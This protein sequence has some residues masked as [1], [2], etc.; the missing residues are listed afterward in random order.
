MG[1]YFQNVQE[2][3]P[4]T[5]YV[6]GWEQ[7]TTSVQ[8]MVGHVESMANPA[9][10]NYF[11]WFD[12]DQSPDLIVED[13]ELTANIELENIYSSNNRQEVRLVGYKLHEDYRII[14]SIEIYLDSSSGPVMEI[15]NKHSDSS[16][17][18]AEGGI[19]RFI[20]DSNRKEAYVAE[21]NERYILNYPDTLPVIKDAIDQVVENINNVQFK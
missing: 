9:G 7:Q 19:V 13:V 17:P 6:Q 18:N 4:S 10:P 3:S 5:L 15:F 11:N 14:F 21:I 1:G 12:Q 20:T 2:I 8:L 16:T